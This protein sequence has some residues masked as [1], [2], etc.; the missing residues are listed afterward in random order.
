[1]KSLSLLCLMFLASASAFSQWNDNT[2]ENLRV[3]S[4]NSS[5]V[6]SVGFAGGKTWIAFYSKS[7][8]NFDMRAQLLD[9]TGKKLLGENG[10]LVSNQP[11]GS[12]LQDFNISITG[13]YELLIGYQYQVAGMLNAVV[14]KVDTSGSLVWGANGIVIGPG[15]S[16]YPKIL[17]NSTTVV[18]YNNATTNTVSL[19][20]ISTNGVKSTDNPVDI[21]VG[22]STTTRGQVA[23]NTLGTFTVVF[24]KKETGSSTTLYAMRYNSSIKAVWS[25]PVQLSDLTTS[26][27]QYYSVVAD[28]DTT[29]LGYA[30]NTGTRFNAYVQRINPA[31]ATALPYG[32]NGS[33]FSTRTGT[34]DPDQQNINIGF[35]DSS[36]VVWATS[37][38]T[39]EALSQSGIY[40]QKFS[41]TTG[42]RLFSNTAR[43][44]FAVT[45]MMDMQEGE[46]A[47]TGDDKPGFL[48]TDLSNQLYATKLDSKG[49]LVWPLKTVTLGS[50][51][52]PKSSISFASND[53]IGVAVWNEDRGSGS[54]A[55][56]QN[57]TPAGVTGV[58]PVLF[59]NFNVVKN[60][61]AA[62]LSWI[63]LSETNNKG[64]YIERSSDGRNFTSIAFMA[65][66]AGGNSSQSISYVY[67]DKLPLSFDNYYRL[68]QVDKDGRKTYSEIIMVNFAKVIISLQAKI[69]PNPASHQLNILVNASENMKLSATISSAS[70][71][72]VKQQ[73]LIVVA[74][75]NTLTL[76]I[77][78]LSAGTYFLQLKAGNFD[79][80]I[81]FTKQ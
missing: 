45:S 7:G 54:M 27:N 57:I 65:S 72:I 5:S 52:K 13:K 80:V 43:E 2:A 6:H 12:S 50:S 63:T 41:K 39:N 55:Y 32:I 67:T 21:K 66:K 25:A 11:S 75:N 38:Y 53:V 1:M 19:Q 35:K 77:Q 60:G 47:V 69:Y 4:F 70:G 18:A 48:S 74:G 40:I 37:T 59:S 24:Q 33:A 49:Q 71:S 16:P 42:Q 14:S 61:N 44:V 78:H 17:S 29:Y 46:L 31:F 68:Q 15:S 9:S 76:P 26:A 8:S 10:V 30:A 28:Y 3:S 73:S 64:F 58:L 79:T 36:Q 56:A 20:S 23:V 34:T 81:P 22:T 62:D 51:D